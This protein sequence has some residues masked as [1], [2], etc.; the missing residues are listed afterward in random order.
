MIGKKIG[1]YLIVE[2]IGDGGHAF[3]FKGMREN[4]PVAIKMLKPSATADDSLE[5]RFLLEVDT[6]KTLDHPNIVGFQ[7]YFFQNKFHYLVMEFMDAGSMDQLLRSAGPVEARYAIPI[8]TQ[9]L[10][11]V[12]HAHGLGYLHRDLKPNNMLLNR[13]GQAKITDFGIAKVLGG[14]SLTKKGFVLGTTA[15][16][17]PE[18]L[19]HGRD[20]EQL[21]VYAL[22][23]SFYEI[24]SGRKP[25]EFEGADETVAA[26]AA[27]VIQGTP[28]PLSTRKPVPAD[29]ER[30]VMKA[31][32]QD[33]RKRYK[34]AD[35]M[36]QDLVQAFPD[37]SNR[38]IQI[39]HGRPRTD[40]VQ[41]RRRQQSTDTGH[42]RPASLWRR[43]TRLLRRR[44]RTTD[45]NGDH[46]STPN[47]AA[48]VPFI[49]EMNEP[50][51]GR[52][53]IT[54][55]SE[56]SAFLVVKSGQDAEKR[57]GLRPIS[58]V[59]R[60]LRFDIRPQD[61]EISRQHAVITF[62]GTSFSIRDLNSANGTFVNEKRVEIERRLEHGDMIRIGKTSMRFE[63]RTER[64]DSRRIM[65]AGAFLLILLATLG[66]AQAPADS[67]AGSRPPPP[68][69]PAP[70][71]LRS[72]PAP[73]PPPAS[74]P[75]PPPPPLRTMRSPEQVFGFAC[76]ADQKFIG[77]QA[78]VD[79][80]NDAT[81]AS[82][83][84]RVEEI[85]KSTLGRPFIAAYVSTPENL[86]RLQEIRDYNRRVAMGEAD[87]AEI[88][89]GR[90]PATVLVTAGI[91]ATEFTGTQAMP[92]LLWSLVGGD[93]APRTRQAPGPVP[94][95]AR[96]LVQPGR[97][98]DREG[99][100][101][102]DARHAV[103][104]NVAA[105]AL[106]PLRRPRQQ[107][108][109]VHADA[110]RV[111]AGQQAPLPRR[112][113]AALRRSAPHGELGRADVHRRD[114]RAAEPERRSS[115]GDERAA[116]GLVHALEDDR[117]G[118]TRPP[119]PREL[120]RVL[121]GRVLHERVVAPHPGDPHR[122]GDD[123]ARV[124]DLPAPRPTSTAG[125]SAASARTATPRSGTTRGPGPADGGG[126]ATASSTTSPRCS[127]R[128]TRR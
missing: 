106:P 39:L 70:S 115:H 52:V 62:D 56:L 119:A 8:F 27:R 69:R 109:R 104:G 92:E 108:R 7:D 4:E 113:S 50:E 38:P 6:L 34:T 121:A 124:P 94:P 118:Q 59:G 95:R 31:I 103:R 126:R 33:P 83:W 29:L 21:D 15:Y 44:S 63:Y 91:H 112:A 64:L 40:V 96:A 53:P 101:R 82:P 32:D 117:R 125:T 71:P 20:S 17:A 127:R 41:M 68:P 93:G 51:P 24:L 111:A 81:K 128:W 45:A 77:W 16:M 12:A 49:D 36:R 99:L 120:E 26:F 86:A 23:V 13:K 54:S 97:P 80:F 107:P 122:D 123:A 66:G 57:F 116:R 98:R 55:S 1:P 60:D 114:V 100:V 67:G 42:R 73:A 85:G 74:Q 47:R 105:R 25:F 84:V 30:I 87:L 61:E 48:R 3:V 90:F 11:G 58:R 88:R 76:G 46:A 75:A 78:I 5:R 18:Y 2:E 10:A 22:G 19:T 14:E 89:S 37:L 28:P 65:R 79:Y 110:G 72:R 35:R 102:E 9:V 43:F